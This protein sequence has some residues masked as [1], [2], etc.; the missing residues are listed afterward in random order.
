MSSSRSTRDT[1][2][3]TDWV[4][5]GGVI[6]IVGGIFNLIQGLA[7][8]LGPDAYY[9]EV[10]GTLLV[11]NVAGWGWWNVFIGALTILT[12]LALLNGALWARIVAVVLAVLSA[13][14]EMILVPVQPWWSFIVIAIDVLVI[15][16]VVAHG[17]DLRTQD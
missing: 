11:F 9:A 4:R 3:S 6:L 16:A 7:A 5:F 1:S 12:G 2:Q 13:I 17:K 15:Y 8:L 14:V 10:N